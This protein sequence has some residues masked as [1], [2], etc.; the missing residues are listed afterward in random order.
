LIET[1]KVTAGDQT[2][3]S[4]LSPTSQAVVSQRVNVALASKGGI[5]FA[6]DII[7]APYSPSHLNDGLYATGF[8]NPW[9]GAGNQ[10]FAG[11]KLAEP[12]TIDEI[13]FQDEFPSRRNAAFIFEYTLDDLGSIPTD[14]TFG[15][16]PA[17]IDAKNWQVLD[18]FQIQDAA[19][20]RY[21]FGFAPIAGVTGVRVRVES[22]QIQTAISEL[23]VWK[24]VPEPATGGLAI[25]GGL[26]LLV[27]RWR[28]R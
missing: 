19:D 8:D 23:E 7:S 10:S 13:G 16:N 11:V 20:T 27:R 15:F 21:L 2:T 26:G 3:A 12:T 4:T 14:S 5:G 28:R 24:A 18:V 17:A 22:S 6:K 1:G 9:I 25:A